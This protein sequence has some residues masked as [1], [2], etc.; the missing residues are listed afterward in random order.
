MAQPWPPG[1]EPENVGD[2]E[3]GT[4]KPFGGECAREWPLGPPGHDYYL[5]VPDPSPV[6]SFTYTPPAPSTQDNVTFD[7]SGSQPGV[8]GAPITAYNWA[9][10]A[11]QTTRSGQVVSWRLPSGH[12]SYDAVLTVTDLD[13]M[14][15]S[16]TQILVI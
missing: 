13:G 7:G 15:G 2:I 1:S 8:N 16:A 12:G 11:G 3:M 6:A 9:F 14:S 10:N 5:G 4:V